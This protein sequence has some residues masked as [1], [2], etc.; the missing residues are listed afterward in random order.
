MKPIQLITLTKDVKVFYSNNVFKLSS[1]RMKEVED[2]WLDINQ[3]N[4]FHRG[5]VFNVQ[6][7]IEQEKNSYKIVLN[8]TDY[9]AIYIP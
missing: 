5:E 8:R 6:S 3:Q 7:M 2:F 1:R 4:S 9:A